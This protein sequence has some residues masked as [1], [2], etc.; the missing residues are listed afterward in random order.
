M[1]GCK[2]KR[3]LTASERFSAL[4]RRILKRVGRGFPGRKRV[5]SC[6]EILYTEKNVQENT[7]KFYLEKHLLLLK[8]FIAGILTA[9]AAALASGGR[10]LLME[11]RFLPRQEEAYTR[12]LELTEPES[13]RT[14]TMEVTV[15]PRER[16]AEE[17]RRLLQRAR[18]E[19]PSSI[20]GE[21]SSLEEVRSPLVLEETVGGLPVTAQWEQ[22]SARILNPDGSIRSDRLSEEGTVTELTVRLCCGEEEER[23][24]FAVRVLPPLLSAEESWIAAVGKA[25]EEAQEKSGKEELKELPETV[26]EKKIVWS[27]KKASPAGWMVL[28]TVLCGICVYRVKD[29]ELE[30]QIGERE[31]QMKRDYARIVSKLVLLTE[32]GSAVRTAWEIIVRDYQKKKEDGRT[33]PRWAYEEMALAGREM[34]NG[35]AETRAYENFGLRC[36]IPCYMKLSALLGQNVRKG[37]KGLGELLYAET[38]EAFEQRKAG[39]VSQ[40]EE[41]ATKLLFPL[42]LTLLAVMLLVIAPA[43]MAMK[44]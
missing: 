43:G 44:I 40:G 36:R 29:Q 35:T 41:A 28:L 13:G 7:E 1:K 8:I 16:T 31:R 39:A 30:K 3:K 42:I 18:E 9:A 27:E 6:M 22:D 37:G 14:G 21:N 15:E 19:L 20:L 38:A 23:C 2:K 32:A 24:R 12:E 26:Q 10:E 25:V 5:E 4:N 11:G 34:Q 33:E 17:N